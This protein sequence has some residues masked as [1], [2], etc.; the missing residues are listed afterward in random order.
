MHY[1]S[2][3]GFHFSGFIFACMLC[4]GAPAIAQQQDTTLQPPATTDT[5][6]AG[7]IIKL[8]EAGIKEAQKS[9]QKFKNDQD[10]LRQEELV[11]NIK[12]TTE[13]AKTY[14]KNIDTAR[15]ARELEKI[16]KWS[17]VTGDGVF[18]NEGTAQTYR[19]LTTT[20]N[21]LREL[22]NRVDARK[23]Q[24]DKYERDLLNFRYRIDSLTADTTLYN[25]PTDSAILVQYLQKLVIA[26][27]SINPADSAL[28]RAIAQVRILQTNINTQEYRLRS[29]LEQIDDYQQK[30]SGEIF[31]REF[32]N[33]WGSQAHA[34]PFGDILTVSFTKGVFVLWFYVQNNPV[35]ISLLFILVIAATVF[36]RSLRS[37]LAQQALLKHNFTGQ[38]VLRHPLLSAIIIVFNLFQFAFSDPPFIFNAILWTTSAIC[39][40]FVFKG[41]ITPYWMRVWLIMFILFLLACINNLALQA[42]R[43]ERWGMLCLAFTGLAAGSYILLNG[44]RAQLREKLILYFIGLAVLLELLSI[45]ANVSGRYNL[46][47]T[48]LITG[49]FNVIIGILF[50]WTIRLINEGL[51]LASSV[52]TKQESKLFYINFDVVGKKSPRLLYLLLVLG[53]FILM[54]RNVYAFRLLTDPLKNFFF[55]ERTIGS[56]SFTISNLLIFFIVVSLAVV[57]SKIVSFFAS[58]KHP[59]G[60]NVPQE[61]KPGLG[62]WILL[63][64]VTIITL[65]LLLGLAAS[66]FP[67]DRITIVLGALGLGVGLGLQTLV[68]NLVSGLIIAFEKPVNVGDVVEISGQAGT[69][70]SIGFRSSIITIWTGADVVIPNGDL[71]NAHLINWTL[72]GGKRKV[73][74]A[75]GVAY[76][77]DLNKAREI[78]LAILNED[79]KILKYPAPAILFQQFGNSSI[80]VQVLFWVRDF[81]EGLPVKSNV[82]MSIDQAFKSNGIVIPFPQTDIHIIS[83]P[84]PVSNK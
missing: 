56:Y 22:L 47:K 29:S 72:G 71:L 23:S 53:W 43:V 15:I 25:F 2:K 18:F 30:L 21:I 84:A 39:L 54:G 74:L 61:R 64:R 27:R 81:R 35:R 70:K 17:E 1:I 12:A 80:D 75:V 24:I 62:S 52:Y 59:V 19:N 33:I 44:R 65:G 41:F 60:T 45:I 8:R 63:I 14:L 40:T 9:I 50:L 49:Y 3:K 83:P 55:S 26:V 78:I 36:L 7:K 69:M 5:S 46:S 68:N 31:K 13:K 42:S 79:E 11:E 66:G 28:T 32:A 6:F 57:I 77:T 4:A 38:L 51:D 67:M 76:G 58:D 48:L 82:I 34:R 37:L 20:G 73:E 16:K 10:A